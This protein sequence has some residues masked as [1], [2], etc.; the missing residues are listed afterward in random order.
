MILMPHRLRF[1]VLEFCAIALAVA[2]R[3][4]ANSRDQRYNCLYKEDRRLPTHAS[5]M[6]NIIDSYR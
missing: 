3:D 6:R 2:R 5:G 1:E 4:I